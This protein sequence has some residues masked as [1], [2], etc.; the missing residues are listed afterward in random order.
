MS[1]FTA[2]NNYGRWCAS[3]LALFLAA[4]AQ[5]Q[6]A[7]D[8]TTLEETQP[9]PPVVLPEPPVPEPLPEPNQFSPRGPVIL[10]LL[11]PTG[12]GVDALDDLSFSLLNAA[13]LAAEELSGGQ[14]I[15]NPYATAQDP[16][17]AA[18]AAQASID[19]DARMIIGPVFATSVEAVAPVARAQG[20][21]VLAL[22]NNPA[23]AQE[24]VWLLGVSFAQRAYRVLT[25]AVAN[26]LLRVGVIHTSDSEGLAA[27]DALR[28]AALLTGAEIIVEAPYERSQ[29]GITDS[30]E[31]FVT[32]ML[33]NE[34]D[35]VVMTDR[36]SGLIYAVSFLPFY[37]LDTE[38]LQI[39][40]VQPLRGAIYANE[41]PLQEAWYA[42]PTEADLSA[43]EAR[44]EARFGSAPHPLAPLAYDAVVVA[45]SL[46]A[47]AGLSRDQTPFGEDDLMRPQGYIGP[48]GVF[49]FLQ[50]GTAQRALSL[51][52]VSRFGGAE[53]AAPV[54]PPRPI[55][56]GG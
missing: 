41:R 17:R 19:D 36:D 21:P 47:D 13:D 10:S 4:C 3:L 34:L 49:R 16:E 18:L 55:A 20:V 48:S 8:T 50:D 25:H 29:T 31:T 51:R 5:Q 15:I 1:F 43:F 11:L 56:L 9:L 40:S 23:V 45:V 38:K 26:E 44:Y 28:E 24:G 14:I 6:P 27:R 22:S 30:A 42:S 54:L 37:G 32:L 39:A 52:S 12:G 2:K 53:L 46:L 35:L 33:E 7:E